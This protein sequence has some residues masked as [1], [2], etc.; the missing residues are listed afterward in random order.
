MIIKSVKARKIANSR[1]QPT[2]EITV[3][4]RFSA[5]APS[6]AS[7]GEHEAVDYSKGLDYAVNFINSFKKLNGI[8]INRFEDIKGIESTVPFLGANPMVALEF[9][10][11]KAASDGEVWKFLNPKA[12][13][14]P[15]PVGNC[16]GGGAHIKDIEAKPDIQEFL[17][18]PKAERFTDAVKINSF[19]HSEIGKMLKTDRITDEGAWSPSMSNLEII[20]QLSKKA[21]EASLKFD[22]EVRLGLDMA[23]ST[24]WDNN[25]K[26]YIYKNFSRK[27]KEKKLDTD[28]QIKFVESLIDDYSLFY[29]ED[30]LRENDFEGFSRIKAKNCLICGDDLIC[31]NVGLLKKAIRQKSVKAIIVKPNQIGSLLKTKEI[32]D[33]AL[34][35]GITPVISHRSGE[36]MDATISHLAVGWGIPFIKCGI[37]GKER[38]IKLKEL[39]KIEG[40]LGF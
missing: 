31:T 29:A 4:E 27:E 13:K 32:V 16:I 17:L 23:S 19:I 24:F 7:T 25:S 40:Q 11:L 12:K 3:N 26:S 28:G 22:A 37:Y 34:G 1:G 36:T 8:S 30:P 5:A 6:G 14:L 33:M 39:I 2:I 15:M 20:E 21:K 35:N 18:I 9:A 38:E 10:A